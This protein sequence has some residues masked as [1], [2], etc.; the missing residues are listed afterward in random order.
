MVPECC[1]E[2]LPAFRWK[3][4]LI[5]EGHGYISEEISKQRFGTVARCSFS[6]ALAVKC[7]RRKI[8]EEK[9]ETEGTRAE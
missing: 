8:T 9:T 5:N 4:E 2:R 6:L 1:P 3:V 7:E